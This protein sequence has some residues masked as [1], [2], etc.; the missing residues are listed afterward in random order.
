MVNACGG[1][2][3]SRLVIHVADLSSPTRFAGR[4]SRTRGVTDSGSQ[5]GTAIIMIPATHP[6]VMMCSQDVQPRCDE[7]F[8]GCKWYG[9]IRASNARG[10]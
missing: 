1:F 6:A 8:L 9:I 7:V 2:L 4:L 3:E 5:N 10:N